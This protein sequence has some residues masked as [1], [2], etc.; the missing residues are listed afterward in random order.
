MENNLTVE[1]YRLNILKMIN[2]AIKDNYKYFT[3]V[4][5]LEIT[6]YK[7]IEN[8]RNRIKDEYIDKKLKKF[9]F[10][11]KSYNFAST[12]NK[13]KILTE[14]YDFLK[15][16][17][18]S[19]YSQR[20]VKPSTFS[21]NKPTN[22]TINQQNIKENA[23]NKSRNLTFT[24]TNKIDMKIFFKQVSTL[25]FVTETEAKKLNKKNIFTVMDILYTLPKKY[26]DWSKINRIESS[27]V[28]EDTQFMGVVKSKKYIT[29]RRRYMEILFSTQSGNLK[30]ILF[31]YKQA[32]F[33]YQIDQ[34]YLIR[35]KL[36]YNTYYKYH[37]I[38][39]R[40]IRLNGKEEITTFLDSAMRY[41]DTGVNEERF[42]E[43]VL[44]ILDN[45]KEKFA[46]FIPY[47]FLK[48]NKYLPFYENMMAL[49]KPNLKEIN[50]SELNTRTS[51][52][53][54]RLKF[55]EF[56]LLHLSNLLKKDKVKKKKGIEIRIDFSLHQ[57]FIKSL[58]FELTEGQLRSISDLFEDLRAKYPAN[59]LIQ[60]DVGSGKTIV[61]ISALLQTVKDGYQAIIMVPTEILAYQHQKTLSKI[62][63]PF[64]IQ[65]QLFVSKMK[66]RVK[67]TVLMQMEYGAPQVFI[68]TH[69][70]IQ[71][72]VKFKN[73]GIVIVDE[74]HRFGVLQRKALQDVAKGVNVVLMS[75]TP[76]PRTLSMSVFGD[77]D[78]SYIEE[79]P[80]SRKPVKTIVIIDEEDKLSD[81]FQFLK[82]EINENKQA[83][84]IFPLIEESNAIEARSLLKNYEELTTKYF[85]GI[86]TAFLHGKLSSIEKEDAMNKFKENEV[87][88]LFSTTVIEV[89][90]DVPNA[91]IMI[92]MNSE[93]FGLSQLH[94]IRGRI[95]RGE[96]KSYCFLVSPKEDVKRLKIMENNRSGFQISRED[97]KLRGPGDL[98]GV[99]Q[100]GVPKFRFV[101]FDKDET[102]ILVASQAANRYIKYDPKFR[103][104]KYLRDFLSLLKENSY[105]EIS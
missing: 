72:N 44:K 50:L 59:R 70:L 14:L 79:M 75:A 71:K 11:L 80:K 83:Y 30:I 1:D 82:T 52:Y 34:D 65:V 29:G 88:I 84:I 20:H 54:E 39:P 101:D 35:G 37:F 74:Q 89:G 64:D 86:K 23:K 28:G 31:N 4:K 2:F 94:Q 69:A 85:K 32:G 100:S 40:I 62:L 102:I 103:K 47:S 96:A 46:D 91:T 26:E 43:I 41:P 87:K 49:H 104:N 77:L 67:D 63:Q 18:F 33:L 12:E 7:I 16:K 8:I 105:W 93:R 38:H 42:S 17:D 76:I 61:A 24:D 60:G 97:L 25:P 48:E 45:Y 27:L 13:Q 73:P 66:K 10:D 53:N 81:M 92:I 55:E 6:L 58:P 98:Y 15:N 9:E 5:N 68:G 90:I 3:Q 21:L 19:P 56:F 57:F 99:E 36:Q 51:I 22:K 78:I 95:G